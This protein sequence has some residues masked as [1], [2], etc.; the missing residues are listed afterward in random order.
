VLAQ[1]KK[2]ADGDGARRI[3]WLKGMA[4]TGKSTIALTVAREYH[5]N[6]RLGASFF[7]SRGGGEL[8]STR[9][10]ATTIAAQLADTLPELRRLIS[11][12]VV[13]NRYIHNLGLYDQW[14]NS[15]FGRCRS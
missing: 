9:R 11:D 4:G 5:D 10:F 15:F 3:Y 2:W 1:I 12:A 8:A 7:F 6:G 14:E 13:S